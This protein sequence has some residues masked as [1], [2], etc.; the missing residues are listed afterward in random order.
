VRTEKS[1]IKHINAARLAGS[2]AIFRRKGTN[3]YRL[4]FYLLGLEL[5]FKSNRVSIYHLVV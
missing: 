5:M 1:K 3:G 4:G 2:E